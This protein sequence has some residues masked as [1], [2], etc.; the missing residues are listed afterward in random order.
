VLDQ[1]AMWQGRIVATVGG[2]QVVCVRLGI[3]ENDDLLGYA[4]YPRE[5]LW[6]AH[7]VAHVVPQD[8]PFQSAAV[9][10]IVRSWYYP[11]HPTVQRRYAD[12]IERC[13]HM[14]SA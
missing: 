8:E 11:P 9:D 4:V 12:L 14:E 2:R 10:R 7:G 6:M 5:R 1:I 3:E 13:R